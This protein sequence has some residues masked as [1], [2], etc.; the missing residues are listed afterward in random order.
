MTSSPG[1]NFLVKSVAVKREALK[2]ANMA[3]SPKTPQPP[4]CP[5]LGSPSL[6]DLS[7]DTRATN[8]QGMTKFL[9]L[10]SIV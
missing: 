2:R 10:L 3:G 9:F 6:D 4:S 5:Q 1:D 7:P 8:S